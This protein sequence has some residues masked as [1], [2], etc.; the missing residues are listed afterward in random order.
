MTVFINR[1]WSFLPYWLQYHTPTKSIIRRL[2]RR[3]SSDDAIYMLSYNAMSGWADC[4]QSRW[5]P[6]NYRPSLDMGA[7]PLTRPRPPPCSL[8][9]H[10]RL[11]D[12][13]KRERN[14]AFEWCGVWHANKNSGKWRWKITKVFLAHFLGLSA[15]LAFDTLTLTRVTFNTTVL[16]FRKWKR[17][18]FMYIDI[19]TYLL[20]SW[21]SV[22]IFH[23]LNIHC[24]QLSPKV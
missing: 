19:L 6:E 2:T 9:F 21:A 12:I 3:G 7:L 24:M 23:L 16:Y 5:I 22:Y 10:H 14:D 13:I 11:A 8:R 4:S 17:T 20:P 1:Y 18:Y 15:G